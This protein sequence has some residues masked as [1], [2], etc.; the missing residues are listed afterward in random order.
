MMTYRQMDHH[1]KGL[2]EPRFKD[3]ESQATENYV[4]YGTCSV[5]SQNSSWGWENLLACRIDKMF[6]QKWWYSCRTA[7]DADLSTTSQVRIAPQKGSLT[8]EE[9]QSTN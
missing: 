5:P 3:V 9:G 7:L 8:Q 6:L 2:E 1:G 4:P